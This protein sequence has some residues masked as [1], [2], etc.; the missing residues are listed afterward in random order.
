VATAFTPTVP[1]AGVSGVA[2]HAIALG[3]PLAQV[4]ESTDAKVAICSVKE[5]TDS[6]IILLAVTAAILAPY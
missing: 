4:E 1:A 6:L 3:R 2:H 5:P